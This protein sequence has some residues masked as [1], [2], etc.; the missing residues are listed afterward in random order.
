VLART[1]Q[2]LLYLLLGI[3]K[4]KIRKNNESII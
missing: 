3:E 1:L 2:Q 4:K